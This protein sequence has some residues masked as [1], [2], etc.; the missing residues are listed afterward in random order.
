MRPGA[1][2][3]TEFPAYCRILH[4]A[5]DS[6]DQRVRWR[7]MA[8]W[9]GTELTPHALYGTIALPEHVPAAPC[10]AGHGDPSVGAM[11]L[12]DF[13]ALVNILSRWH[14]DQET[15]WA[16][17]DGYGWDHRVSVVTAT[18]ERH[19]VPDSVPATV[20]EGPRLQLP[21][22]DYLL[23][24]G[25]AEDAMDFTRQLDQTPNLWWA[26]DQSWCLATEIDLNYTYVGG[27]REL[28]ENMVASD[29]LE[30]LPI[31]VNDARRP[32]P[33]AWLDRELD[34][35]VHSLLTIGHAEIRTEQGV[36]RAVLT[37]DHDC[38]GTLTWRAELMWRAEHHDREAVA[39][40]IES[41]EAF[42]KKLW[43]EL[44]YAVN[45]LAGDSG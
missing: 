7:E 32:M 8:A 10:P 33:P 44:W 13:S 5:Y 38:R 29:L 36:V 39:L 40:Q 22:R 18:G 11:D 34:K 43:H 14:P 20:R 12:H 37:S 27:S 30:A 6:Q 26:V 28:I 45:C 3:P 4:P 2:V 17:W 15:W 19:L 41:P 25:T 23:V 24:H 21:Y 1:T 35:A 9:A 42:K 16:V 31:R